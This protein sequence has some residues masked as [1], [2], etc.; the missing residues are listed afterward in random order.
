MLIQVQSS[1]KCTEQYTIVPGSPGRDG[2]AG[3]QGVPGRTGDKGDRGDIGPPGPKGAAGIVTLTGEYLNRVSDNVTARINGSIIA[4]LLDTVQTL[5]KTFI[6]RLLYLESQL[7]TNTTINQT[8][9]GRSNN[10]GGCTSLT[11]T[12]QPSPSTQQYSSATAASSSTTVAVTLQSTV[13]IPPS[14][15]MATTLAA[16]AAFPS[17]QPSSTVTTTPQW[18]TAATSKSTTV[19]VTLQ[20]TVQIPPSPSMATTLAAAF[21][22]VQ[23]SSTVTT[24]PQWSTAATSR[25]TTIAVTLQS[26]VQIPPSLSMATTLAASAAFPS[27]QPSSTVTTTPQWSTA[28]TSKS[29]TVAVTPQSSFAIPPSPSVSSTTTPAFS[30]T[31]REPLEPT[32]TPTP[33]PT[34]QPLSCPVG[35]T[36]DNPASSCRDILACNPNASSQNYWIQTE[37]NVSK[38]MYCY[39]EADKCGVRGMMR[40]VN[41]D[42]TNPGEI[43]PSPLTNYTVNGTRLCG[44]SNPNGRTCSSVTF[45]TFDY[46]YTHVCGRAVGFSYHHPCAFHYSIYSTLDGAYVAGLSITHGAPGNRTHIWTYAGGYQESFSHTCNCPCAK[47]PGTSAPSYVG[48]NYYCESA[49]RYNP[50]ESRRQ[51]FTNN[52]LWDNQDCYPGSNCCNNPQAP[53]FVRELTTPTQDDVEI[54]WCTEQGLLRDRVGTEL[55]EIYVY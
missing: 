13:Q 12:V 39:M 25:S 30:T 46:H 10:G 44:G 33:L 54:R 1:E 7:K 16:S 34:S 31:V 43:C 22:S 27:V 41:I 5:N 21:P 26:T 40:V 14:P 47:F 37:S 45:S 29:T 19:A 32:F 8:A 35:L 51:W 6:D 18:S 48:D 3:V 2:R 17:V 36:E 20:S 55:V 15:S 11:T 4:E 24:T 9:C 42:M 50:I 53:W 38:S 49:T 52:T 28:A 23:P